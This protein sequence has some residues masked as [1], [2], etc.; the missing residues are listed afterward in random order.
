M[1]FLRIYVYLLI[2]ILVCL[3]SLNKKIK[4]SLQF[5]KILFALYYYLLLLVLLFCG[6]IDVREKGSD[7]NRFKRWTRWF[8]LSILEVQFLPRSILPFSPSVSKKLKN[9][10]ST[11]ENGFGPRSTRQT[12]SFLSKFELLLCVTIFF[13]FSYFWSISV[14]SIWK[15]KEMPI[16]PF[17]LK[18]KYRYSKHYAQYQRFAWQFLDFNKLSMSFSF[19]GMCISDEEQEQRGNNI[20]SNSNGFCCAWI[21]LAKVR[22]ESNIF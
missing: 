15:T 4:F 7:K 8:Y 5:F 17:N 22:F 3:L 9:K 12:G 2:F 10:P 1:I 13:S 11:E 14:L 20:T 21:D 19:D 16:I 6:V 18:Q